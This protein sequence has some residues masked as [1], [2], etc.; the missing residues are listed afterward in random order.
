MEV[1][2]VCSVASYG[3]VVLFL[4]LKIFWVF[5]VSLRFEGLTFFFHGVDLWISDLDQVAQEI[6]EGNK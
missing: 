4:L 3:S 6:L 2:I 5:A 1:N